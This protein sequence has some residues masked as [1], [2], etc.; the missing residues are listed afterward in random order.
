MRCK[1]HGTSNTSLRGEWQ[2]LHFS[3]VFTSN[4]AVQYLEK[5]KKWQ[6]K[7]FIFFEKRNDFDMQRKFFKQ[8]G[9]PY[10]DMDHKFGQKSI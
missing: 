7:F 10:L 6:I 5:S 3:I 2:C 8:H 1:V 9:F 4:F